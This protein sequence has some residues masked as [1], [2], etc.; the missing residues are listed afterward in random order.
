[1]RDWA[2]ARTKRLEIS[3]IRKMFEL[4]KPG[5]INLGIGELDFEPIDEA[6]QAL[7][8]AIEAKPDLSIGFLKN[9]MPTK[10]AGGLDPYLDGLRKS[11][12]E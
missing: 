10:H 12:L 7:A 6:K 11:G 9:N 3:G 5:T 2:A 1:M 8:L 4:A